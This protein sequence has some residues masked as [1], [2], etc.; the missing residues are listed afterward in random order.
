MRWVVWL[1]VA[2]AA[3]VGLSLLMRFNYGNVAILWP[4]YRIEVSANLALALLAAAFVVLHV[5]LIATS[6][7]LRLPQRVR[8]YRTRRQREQATAALRDSVLAFFEGRLGRVERYAQA[9]QAHPA[10][11]GAAALI[12]ARSAQRMQ[13]Q[14]RRDRWLRQAGDSPVTAG[15]LLMTQAEFA[16]EDRRTAEAID[17]VERLHVRGARHIVSMRT[18][19]RAYEQAGRWD[20]VLHTLR[21][22][23][24]RDALHPAA[25]RR[26]RVKALGEMVAARGGDAPGLREAWR[27]LRADERALPEVAAGFADAL[28][29]AGAIDDARRIVEQGLDAGFGAPL[30]AAYARLGG[31][32]LRSRLERM[33]G[34]RQRYGDEPD[35]LLALGR[36]CASEKLWGKAED[37]LRLALRGQPS[38]AAHAALGELQEAIGR[39]E[40]AAEQFRAAARLAAGDRDALRLAP[41]QLAGPAEVPRL[42]AS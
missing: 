14:E 6:R 24:K 16:V 42:T 25:M 21:L 31:I 27:S 28:A 19:L 36:V 8:D 17:I 2:F 20:D 7:A 40:E 10:T 15:A 5:A 18:A 38:V 35:L 37:Y 32:P 39:P 33:E 9:A 26:L 29:E 4:P 23:E 30:A 12:A 11:A 34:W 3:A 41:V 22:L 13:E 1:V